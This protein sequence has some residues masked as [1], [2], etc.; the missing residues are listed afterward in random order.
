MVCPAT[1]I[2]ESQQK[3]CD[4]FG[5]SRESKSV[6]IEDLGPVKQARII[7]KDATFASN[8][9][10]KAPVQRTGLKSKA[11]REKE[12]VESTA[13]LVQQMKDRKAMIE[14][15]V[16][17]G[18][19]KTLFGTTNT[20]EALG[21]N[22]NEK[23]FLR[24]LRA[25]GKSA[26]ALFEREEAETG[27]ARSIKPFRPVMP[28][29]KAKAR[30]VPRLGVARS[31]VTAAS[32]AAKNASLKRSLDEHKKM[33]AAEKL[34]FK[35]ADVKSAPFVKQAKNSETCVSA[36]T[37][38]KLPDWAMRAVV[39]PSRSKSAVPEKPKVAGPIS[40]VSPVPRAPV[41]GVVAGI[42]E[43]LTEFRHRL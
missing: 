6:A 36:S 12:W 37:V 22:A 5:S 35:D 30:T 15:G 43:P 27:F 14:A 16:N 17:P 10:T 40:V 41:P 13:T 38:N 28:R 42:P 39:T 34:Q 32:S 18:E 3:L 1:I 26:K 20:G 33:A 11:E 29:A 2:K 21:R 19:R 4:L 9:R 7:A 24:Q 31:A 25:H 8:I 23:R